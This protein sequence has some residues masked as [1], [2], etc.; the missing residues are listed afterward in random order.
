MFQ[1]MRLEAHI[2]LLS[3]HSYQVRS[4]LETSGRLAPPNRSG[5]L[6][7]LI[8]NMTSNH[9]LRLTTSEVPIHTLGWTG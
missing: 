5:Y 8:L 3:L 4:R 1:P 9:R 7:P 6:T 2:L